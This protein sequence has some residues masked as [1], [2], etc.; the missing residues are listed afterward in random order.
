[1]HTTLGQNMDL[2]DMGVQYQLPLTIPAEN[3]WEVMVE[4][5]Y[6][7]EKFLP[8]NDV[9]TIDIIPGE[10][11]YRE[12]NVSGFILKEDVYL[13]PENYKIRFVVVDNDAV[14][15]NKYH[16]DTG[17]IEYFQENK[18]GERST[19]RIPRAIILHAMLQTHEMAERKMCE[20]Y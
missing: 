7:P 18:K 15:I 8:V 14:H 9:K 6:H 17:V 16:P 20:V 1:M 13:D 10:H 4:K 5:I 3:V 12:M 19:W 2:V 11:V